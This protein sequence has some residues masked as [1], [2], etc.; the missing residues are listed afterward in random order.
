MRPEID[1]EMRA[2]MDE[3]LE[4]LSRGQ[5][6]PERIEPWWEGRRENELT[7]NYLGRVL[8][9]AGLPSMARSARSGSYD[10]YHDED[11]LGLMRLVCELRRAARDDQS[12]RERF[13]VIENAVRRGEFDAIKAE[14]D[15]WAASKAGQDNFRALYND[16]KKKVGRNDPC[17]CGSGV[18]YKRC[19]GG[20]NSRHG[21]QGE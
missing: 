4:M 8:D 21:D 12:E 1:D 18:K 2:L 3:T 14:S 11:G 19:H 16:V 10:D 7:P 17:P 15:R 13:A 20:V 9:E 6:E 5:M